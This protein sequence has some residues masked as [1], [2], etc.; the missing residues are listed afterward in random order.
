[1]RHFSQ[2]LGGLSAAIALTAHAA[3]P[4]T[5][6]LSV[7]IYGLQSNGGKV[8]CWL[9]DAAHAKGYPTD[10]TAARALHWGAIADHNATLSFA[11]LP[12]GTYALAC[13]HDENGNGKL[14]TNWIGIPKEGMV[15]SNNAKGR[16]GPPK[17]DDAK[18]A[19]A[20]PGMELKLKVKY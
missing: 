18:F 13:F 16:M 19:F 5:G 14:D 8:G 9:Y 10:A 7:N 4:A 20:A 2:L 15:A 12:A 3:E 17:F 11:D 6:A 1:M